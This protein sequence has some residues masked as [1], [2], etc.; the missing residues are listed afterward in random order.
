MKIFKN[1]KNGV[2]LFGIFFLFAHCNKL[3]K[4]IDLSKIN[5]IFI[6]LQSYWRSFGG[7]KRCF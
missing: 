2:H 7:L 5:L 4:V 1:Y 3:S 6:A